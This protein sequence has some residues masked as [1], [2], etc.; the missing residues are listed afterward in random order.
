MNAGARD[1][2]RVLGAEVVSNFGTMLRRLAIMW[3][4]T[5]VLQATPFEMGLLLVADVLAGALGSLLLGV[6]LMFV[7]AMFPGSRDYFQKRSLNRD[8]EVLAPE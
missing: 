5:L 4:A 8:T 7:W 3:I 6:V 2:R 1:F